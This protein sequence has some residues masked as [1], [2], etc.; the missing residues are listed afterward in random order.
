MTLRSLTRAAT[1]TSG[2]GRGPSS[3][4]RMRYRRPTERGRGRHRAPVPGEE[5]RRRAGQLFGEAPGESGS[6][7]PGGLDAG[8][9]GARVLG[10]RGVGARGLGAG[11]H[12]AGALAG[13]GRLG[14]PGRRER[15]VLALRDRVPMWVQARCGVERRGVVALGVVLVLA[16]VLAGQHFWA[17]RTESVS[18]P[19]V[20]REAPGRVKGAGE[21]GGVSVSASRSGQI[22]VDVSGKV[23]DPGVRRL[24]SGSRVADALKA[25]GGVRPGVREEGLNRARFLV[26]GEQ[27][28]VGASGAPPPVG[29]GAVAPAGGGPSAPVSLGTATVEQLDTLPGVGPVLAQRIIDY[30]TQ[31]GGFRSVD[32]LR[33]VD[34]I[35]DRRFSDLRARVGP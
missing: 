12:G 5:V 11:A 4:S 26:D 20:V 27:I 22:V 21:A 9:R 14:D 10:A 7:P 15:V 34:G 35:G 17:G 3:D 30:R 24:P 2:P 31:H 8:V 19:Q 13:E 33:Q 25:A 18:A 28:V 16:A 1:P 29:V 6:G 32:E 23:R